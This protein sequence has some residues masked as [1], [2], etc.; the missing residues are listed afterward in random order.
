MP[1][2]TA[3]TRLA[4]VVQKSQKVCAAG[5]SPGHLLPAV[6]ATSSRPKYLEW[7]CHKTTK[8]VDRA[9]CGYEHQARDEANAESNDPGSQVLTA[10]AEKEDE[11]GEEHS[12]D[13]IR[14]EQQPDGCQQSTCHEQVCS[15]SSCRLRVQRAGQARE[16]EC[17]AS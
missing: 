13:Q 8:D 9:G 4:I 5:A 6:S 15:P 1:P 12:H 11:E 14:P 3:S 16:R 2:A 10:W 7:I 17:R